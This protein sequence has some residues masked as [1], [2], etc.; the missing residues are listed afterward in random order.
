WL[1][2]NGPESDIVVSTRVRVARN[3]AGRR[4]PYRASFFE[5]SSVFDEVS[6]AVP[7]LP[8]AKGLQCLNFDSLGKLEQELLAENRVVSPDMLKLEGDRGVACDSS[9]RM[10]IMINEEDH[11]RVQCMD[12]G[13]RAEDLWESVDALDDGL[14]ERL[15]YS[16]DSRLGF[17]T[18]CPTNAGTGLRVSFLLHLPGLVL[19]KTID[20]VLQGA[21]QMGIST[22]GFFGEHSEV[23]GNFFQLSNHAT[24]GA[25]EREFL[26][27]TKGVIERVIGFEREARERIVKA[28]TAELTDK[29][30]R[31]YGILQYARMLQVRELLNLA[32]ALRLGVEC[33]VF[34]D[35]T[36]ETINRTVLMA[37]P[38]HLQRYRGS[39]MSEDEIAAARAELVRD[40]LSRKSRRSRPSRRTKK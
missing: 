2:G 18:C 24:M 34:G 17:L 23:V 9:C 6:A 21:S 31:A 38:A 20:Q 4:F 19:T 1:S 12:A 11:I 10:S 35:A 32:S 39:E 28:A 15:L 40:M 22:R 13:L 5:R 25:D 29:A 27:N 33:G 30:W 7:A 37:M 8:A 36:V 26:A 3:L 14:G 16:Y